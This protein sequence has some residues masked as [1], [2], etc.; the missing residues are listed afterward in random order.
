MIGTMASLR[1]D[2]R[3]P[4]IAA[5]FAV[6]VLAAA[7][8]TS[9]SSTNVM[10]VDA[11][12]GRQLAQGVT[13]NGGCGSFEDYNLS[14]A[15]DTWV[16][17]CQKPGMTFEIVAYG[18]ADARS[19]GIKILDDQRAAYVSHTFYAVVVLRSEGGSAE[20]ALASFKK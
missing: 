9:P 14:R 6:L 20:S 15:R 12:S 7:C 10:P 13:S 3:H 2:H 16:F 8:S 19:A 5:A 18:S 11:N 17:T 1:T 4:A